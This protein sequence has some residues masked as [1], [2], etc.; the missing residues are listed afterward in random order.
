MRNMDRKDMAKAIAE[1]L[2]DND[3]LDTHNF[4]GDTESILRCT[5]E[6]ILN[7]LQDYLIILG[8]LL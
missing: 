7:H 2:L 6:V 5:Q 8:S 1:E 3:I 4:S